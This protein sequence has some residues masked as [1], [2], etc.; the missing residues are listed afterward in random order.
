MSEGNEPFRWW[1]FDNWCEPVA[2]VDG[3]M[4]KTLWEATYGNDCE[5]RKFTTRTIP[6]EMELTQYALT[7]YTAAWS[8]KLGYEVEND[9][10]NHGGGLHCMLPNGYLCCHLDYDLHPKLPGKR[11]ALNLIAFLNP[12]WEKSWGGALCLCDPMGNVVKRFY[13][14]PGLLVAFECSDLA[15]HMVEP[16]LETGTQR[17]TLA[18]NLLAEATGKET[19]R[20][21]L[22]MPNRE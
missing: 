15:Y 12:V 9:P 16:I 1:S 18:V 14:Q 22:F 7:N 20:R 6:R 21:A 4:N 19:R 5:W 11:R 10:T 17:I 13:P 3:I 8:V 2:D